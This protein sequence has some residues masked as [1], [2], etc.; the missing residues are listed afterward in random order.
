MKIKEIE[1]KIKP[2]KDE[3]YTENLDTVCIVLSLNCLMAE[4]RA[5]AAKRHLI[6][7]AAGSTQYV[8]FENA[9]T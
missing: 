6:L 8:Y 9:L 4:E 1:F 7:N 2:R 3:K 5:K